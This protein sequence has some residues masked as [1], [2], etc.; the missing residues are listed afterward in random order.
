MHY[1]KE[2]RA[3]QFVVLLEQHMEL[4]SLGITSVWPPFYAPANIPI[5]VLY[6]KCSLQIHISTG[7]TDQT[8]ALS[9]EI[10][11]SAYT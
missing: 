7:P 10:L 5:W 4:D 1:K 2:K 8:L 3:S 11:T 9:Q 6:N